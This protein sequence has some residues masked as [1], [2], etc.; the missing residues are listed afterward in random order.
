MEKCIYLNSH[1]NLTFISGEHIIPAGLGGIKKLP[2]GYVSD[3]ANNMFSK[4]EKT[5]L[6]GS[7]LTANRIRHGPGKRGNQDLAKEKNPVVRLL[8]IDETKEKNLGYI[9]MGSTYL[10]P[11]IECDYNLLSG[12]IRV[13]FRRDDYDD[14]EHSKYFREFK[15]KLLEFLFDRNK[16]YTQLSTLNGHTNKFYIGLLNNQ[17]I[18]ASSYKNF[19]LEKYVKIMIS[20]FFCEAVDK[21]KLFMPDNYQNLGKMLFSFSQEIDLTDKSFFYLILKIAFN[22]LAYLM[23]KEIVLNKSFDSIRNDIV[24]QQNVEKYIINPLELEG[25]FNKQVKMSNNEHY[26]VV[27]TVNNNVYAYVAL[28]DEWFGH[29]LLSDEYD[30]QPF[31]MEYICDWKNKNEYEKI[32]NFI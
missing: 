23:G 12:E 5:A 8:T 22:S 21:S 6:R 27:K 4:F 18:V 30:G 1:E 19:D 25:L 29:L 32:N 28:Y 11:Q 3:Q 24:Y 15:K 26:I 31:Y 17:W 14:T 9:F 13:I 2:K 16:K 20:Y 10:I 7:L